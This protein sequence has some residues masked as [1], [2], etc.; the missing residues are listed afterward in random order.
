MSFVLMYVM[1]DAYGRCILS[2]KI[3]FHKRKVRTYVN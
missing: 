3:A 2:S 1:T